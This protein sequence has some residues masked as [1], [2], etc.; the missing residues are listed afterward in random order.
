MIRKASALSSSPAFAK[1]YKPLLLLGRRSS[2]LLIDL[3]CVTVLIGY[4][5]HFT[6]P[7]LKGGFAEDEM[8]NMS[9]YWKPGILKC[10]WANICF[11]TN[12][13]RPAGAFYYLPLYHFFSLDPQPYRIVQIAIV[14]AS[15]PIIYWQR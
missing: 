8:M 1:V 6:L 7:S 11:W 14:A 5:L 2:E 3:A 15:I 12:F 10:V 4:F 9:F 13:H